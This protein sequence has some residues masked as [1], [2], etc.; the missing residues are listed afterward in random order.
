[1][2]SVSRGKNDLNQISQSS[3]SRAGDTFLNVYDIDQV[4][5]GLN[6]IVMT[7]TGAGAFHVGVELYG[8]EWSYRSCGPEEPGIVCSR[9]R[10]HLA[11]IYR[12]SLPMGVT[13]LSENQVFELMERLQHDWAGPRYH[14]VFKNCI[15]FAQHLCQRLNVGTVPSWIS[16]FAEQGIQIGRALSVESA[17]EPLD[18]G[19]GKQSGTTEQVNKPV[20]IRIKQNGDNANRVSTPSTHLSSSQGHS[21]KNTPLES[22]KAPWLS[23]PLQVGGDDPGSNLQSQVR[24]HSYFGSRE[25]HDN[26]SPS[27]LKT[28][29]TSNALF[30]AYFGT[31]EAETDENHVKQKSQ[32]FSTGDEEAAETHL[33]RKT[34]YKL[35]DQFFH[36]REE[37]GQ[38]KGNHGYQ[39]SNAR[40]REEMGSNGY[41]ISDTRGVPKKPDPKSASSTHTAEVPRGSSQQARSHVWKHPLVWQDGKLNDAVS[42]HVENERR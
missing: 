21:S 2:S 12:E 25:Q 28:R 17:L 33:K 41:P 24:F 5:K 10:C 9:P 6:S 4:V 1:M 14:L 20:K 15:H 37:C 13:P 26:S 30:D 34:S 38:E 27:R 3:S 7:L 18:E 29:Q 8:R 35:F 40:G 11:H 23:E 32:Y 42:A 16:K 19:V 36:S 31:R 39:S 22:F